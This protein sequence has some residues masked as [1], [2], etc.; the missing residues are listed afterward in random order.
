VANVPFS[1]SYST[2]L[3][4]ITVTLGWVSGNMPHTRSMQTYVGQAGMQN[5]VYAQ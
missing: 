4:Q 2:N 3:K 5:Y 1:N